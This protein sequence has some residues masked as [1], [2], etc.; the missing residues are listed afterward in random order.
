MYCG[1]KTNTLANAT[2]MSLTLAAFA[3]HLKYRKAVCDYEYN[4]QHGQGNQSTEGFIKLTVKTTEVNAN[5]TRKT[6]FPCASK[7]S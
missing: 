4:E 5:A 3:K 7:F 1:S 2:S 6:L